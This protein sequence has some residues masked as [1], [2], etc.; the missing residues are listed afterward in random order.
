MPDVTRRDGVLNISSYSPNNY[1]KPDLGPK[2]YVAKATNVRKGSHGSTKL[3][4]DIADAVNVMTYAKMEDGR[5]G[6]AAWDIF[7]AEDAS[8]VRLSILW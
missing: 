3:H 8:K 4:M 7:R 1:I 6:L 5:D 2:M